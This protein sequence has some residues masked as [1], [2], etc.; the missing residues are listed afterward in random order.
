M[1]TL[2]RAAADVLRPFEPERRHR[3]HRVRAARSCPRARR[4]ERRSS[5]SRRGGAAGAA[6]RARARRGRGP[7]GRRPAQPRVRGPA[8]RVHGGE[9]AE[10]LAYDPQTA[11]GLLISL[12]AEKA[13]VLE[14]DV[15]RREVCSCGASVAIEPGAGVVA[16]VER[17]VHS[18]RGLGARPRADARGLARR[19]SCA[20]RSFSV[21]LAVRR[22]HDRRR[23]PPDGVR[24]RLRQLAALR[25][26]AVPREGRPRVHRVRQPRDRVRLDRADARRVARRPTRVA[27]CPVWVRRLALAVWLGTV[28]QIPLGGITVIFNLHPLLVMSHFLL[29]LVVLAGAVVVA[30]E[31]WALDARSVRPARCRS[32]GAGWR[33]PASGVCLALVVTGA[34]VERLGPALGREGHPP[35]RDRHRRHRLR[36]RARGRRVRGRFPARRLVAAVT[37][38]RRRVSPLWPAAAARR[39]GRADGAGRGAVPHSPAVVARADPRR[40]RRGDLVG[41]SRARLLD[42]APPRPLVS[43]GDSRLSK[44]RAWQNASCASPRRPACGGPVLIAAFQ[45]WNDGGQARDARRRLPRAPWG[46]ERFADIDPEGFVDFQATRPHVSLDDG[47]TRQ[48][49]WPENAFYHAPIPSSDR[50]AVIMLGVEPNY[51][52]RTFVELTVGLAQ[53]ARR[54][55]RRH[56]RRAARRRSAHAAV[57]RHRRGDRRSSS[58]SSGCGSRDTRARPGSSAC[59]TTLPPAGMPSVSLWAAV[60]HYVSLAPSP[61]AAKA[62]CAGSASCSA[63][64]ST[65]D[66][67]EEAERRVRGA[68]VRGGRHRRGDRGLRRGARAASRLPRAFVDEGGL[69]SG[70]SIAAELTRFLR[71]REQNGDDEQGPQTG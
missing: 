17:D 68:G 66:E 48:I 16:A 46:A 37:V 21:L 23:R 55:A 31:A 2:N 30:L 41:H 51:R 63:C 25:L 7:H 57:A 4:A 29:A 67:L 44:L 42:L 47:M 70:D 69:P 54:R 61:R 28:A 36:P 13:A 43:E 39:A 27:S 45:G 34:V 58:R 12:P 33:S 18:R 59:S 53:R 26:D 24:S 8:R 62:L 50:D 35:A 56:A 11:G 60:P 5:R 52:W 19:G 10:A 38:A 64:R 22:R 3:R 32:G 20:W 65:L 14:A 9:A 40:A 6:G 1:K 49:D 15:R 71:E